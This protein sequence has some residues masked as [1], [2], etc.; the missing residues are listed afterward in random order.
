MKKS[1]S[2]KTATKSTKVIAVKSKKVKNTNPD[3]EGLTKIGK[4]VNTGKVNKTT[5]FKGVHKIQYPSG[6]TMFRARLMFEGI[7]YGSVHETAKLAAETYNKLAI[8]FYGKKTS[9]KLNILNL[10]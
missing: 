4:P 10:I 9:N 6:K 8:K 3:S 5:G 7:E 1:T 2:K